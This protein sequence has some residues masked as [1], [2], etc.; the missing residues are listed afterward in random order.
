MKITCSY[1]NNKFNDTMETCPHCGA[2]NEGVVRTSAS[3]P[4]TIE[5]L[6]EWY[7]SKG[8]PPYE[9]TRFFIGIDYK[10]P[11]AFGIYKDEVSGNFVV[12]KNKASGERSIRYEGTDEAYAVNELFQR[13]KQEIIQQKAANVAKKTSSGKSKNSSSG[14]PARP[15]KWYEKHPVLIVFLILFIP[16]ALLS[17]FTLVDVMNIPQAGYYLC[18]NSVYYHMSG[19][20]RS[21]WYRYD[22]NNNWSAYDMSESYSEIYRK[23]DTADQYLL[24]EK[25][26]SSM[27]CSDIR[28]NI[29]YQDFLNGFKVSPGY[30]DYY[31]KTYYHL[32]S[33]D[34][35]DWYIF[36]Y[37]MGD[38][39]TVDNNNIPD[40]L[41]HGTVAEDFY[42]T[43]TWDSSTQLY[44]FEDSALYASYVDANKSSDSGWDDDDDYDYSWDDSYDWDSGSSDWDSDW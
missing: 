31:D 35:S 32:S 27:P 34:C 43:P 21:Y 30:Y 14:K 6:A 26:N 40:D 37:D 3:Q 15:M 38:W 12:Y 25:W 41:T 18:D 39:E 5:E 11:K 7:K 13:L 44:D 42:F 16:M 10:K 17:T 23:K 24:G 33:S 36:N 1:C 4:T 19:D 22:G 8:L 9:K 28:D 29:V 2:P 20:D